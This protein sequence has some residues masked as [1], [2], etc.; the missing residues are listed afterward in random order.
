MKSA[1]G[2]QHSVHYVAVSAQPGTRTQLVCDV[3]QGEGIQKIT[4]THAGITGPAEVIVYRKVVF[5][6]GN[7]FTMRVFFGFS[8]RQATKYAGKWIFVTRARPEFAAIADGATFASFVAN[9]FPTDQLSLVT[10]GNLIGVRGTAQFEGLTEGKTVLAP[11]HGTPL[12]VKETVTYPGHTGHDLS[13]MSHWNEAVHVTVP[14]NA[15]PIQVVT[16]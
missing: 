11:A 7:A 10:P 16:G 8:P 15:I 3:G 6:K 2:A 4:L 9:L 1:V 12:P 14:A 13:T 5:L